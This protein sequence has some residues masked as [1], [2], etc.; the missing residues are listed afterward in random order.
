[1][2]D[3]KISPA[4]RTK[5]NSDHEEREDEF[6]KVEKSLSQVAITAVISTHSAGGA[7]PSFMENSMNSDGAKDS[8]SE[9]SCDDN[10]DEDSEQD[11]DD[12]MSRKIKK[13]LLLD[14]QFFVVDREKSSLTGAVLAYCNSCTVPKLLSGSFRSTSNFSSHLKRK[15]Q[16][17][18][19]RYKEYVRLKRQGRVTSIIDRRRWSCLFDQN[20]FEEN[21]TDFILKFMLPF[22]VVEDPGF[23]K[24]FDDFKIQKGDSQIKH[25]TRYTLGKR[26]EENLSITM[27]EIRDQ[28]RLLI[29]EGG[30]VC[31][32][33]DVWTGGA[34][35]F[36][37]VTVS[38]IE[39]KTLTRKSA[40]IACRR[41]PGTHSFDA[42]ANLL[43][44]IHTS[45]G[46][47]SESIRA[48]V[49]DNASNF[50]KAFRKLGIEELDK[51]LPE[52]EVQ[53]EVQS[54]DT[55]DI[56]AIEEYSNPEDEIDIE[57]EFSEE[58]QKIL[59]RHCKCASHTMN[60]I[61]S[62]DVPK[63][64]ARNDPL[65]RKHNCVLK[66]CSLLWKLL[67]SPKKRETL[68]TELGIA[69][70]RPVVTRWNSSYDCFKQ[71]L[72]IK[73]KLIDKNMEG[74][75]Q[76]FTAGDFNYLEEYVRCS[77]PLANAIDLLQGDTCY[78]GILLPTLVSM[79][80]QLNEL[81]NSDD[82]TFCKPLIKVMID[83]INRRFEKLFDFTELNV[84]AAI[85]AISHPRFKGR[86]LAQFNEDQQRLIHRRFVEA[87]SLET[88]TEARIPL[89]EN[90]DDEFQFGP[91]AETIAEF[92]PSL[93]Q[94]EVKA[95]VTRYLKSKETQLVMLEKFP[96]IR[97]TFLKYNTPLP[98]SAP[99][100][101]LFSYA[102][103][104]NMPKFNRISEEH[105]EQRILAKA[106]HK[107]KYI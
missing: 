67:R 12:D 52:D 72:G 98:S 24:I 78:Y 55:D 34:R 88:L 50:E 92:E 2:A 84:D 8:Y 76:P 33:A 11:G 85:A 58:C 57:E 36:L 30:L 53:G 91:S 19:A 68:K 89:D 29:N 43:S 35:R 47:T 48:T 32:T 90:Q 3:D 63:A 56:N 1:M 79:R 21:V 9:N 14:G 100:E 77:T 54:I 83:G 62:T 94:G 31:T 74:L 75:T 20:K 26:V 16:E 6:N 105:F 59:P 97:K 65:K 61:A 93:S 28:L 27:N 15:H 107:K 4:K 10:S 23:R 49:T 46:L 41:F 81:S 73:A 40:A 22:R 37:G 38:W 60:L 104:M 99:V 70:Q 64:I 51:V 44:S 13:T 39:P 18:H 66:K 69:I 71:L 80:Y 101:R 102:T 95:E 25:L 17:E 86:W 103:M 87:V 5:T 45:F 42:I 7:G 96:N 106:N 82:V